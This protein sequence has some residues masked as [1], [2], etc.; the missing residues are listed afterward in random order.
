LSSSLLEIKMTAVPIATP[1]AGR[2][3]NSPPNVHG[4]G[5]GSQES[6]EEDNGVTEI[7]SLC[8]NCHDNVRSS[9]QSASKMM[10]I[11]L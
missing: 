4:A 11:Y 10:L 7:E 8:M 2:T 5:Q 3:L 6:D 9:L 1:E